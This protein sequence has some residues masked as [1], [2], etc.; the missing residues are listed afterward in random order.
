MGRTSLFWNDAVYEHAFLGRFA[1]VHNLASRLKYQADITKGVVPIPCHSHNDYWR[2]EPLFD[3]IRWGCTSVEADVWLF[4]GELYV[5]HSPAELTEDRT[6]QSL[7]INPLLE[8]LEGSISTSRISQSA[9]RGIFNSKPAQTLVL[10]IDFKRAGQDTLQVV[11][12]QLQP[13]RGR[14]LLSFW[15]GEEVIS[16]AVTIVGTG[17]IPFDMVV[18]N[19]SYRDIFL[20]APLSAL[21]EPPRESIGHSDVL[22]NK[23]GEIDYG[24]AMSLSEVLMRTPPSSTLTRICSIRAHPTMLAPLSR[25]PLASCGVV[26]FH[27]GK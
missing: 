15:D 13:L 24:S 19:S 18:D 9:T 25:L 12:Q 5:G 23:D 7:Y 27:P 8:L 21:W 17:N 2:D 11:Q 22:H 1:Q 3:A 10:L 20:D 26:I 6:L 14:D 16:R 4:D